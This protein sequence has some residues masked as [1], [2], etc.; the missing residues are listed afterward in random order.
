MKARIK[1]GNDNRQPQNSGAKTRWSDILNIEEGT[2]VDVISQ[3]EHTNMSVIQ[4][5]N[6][7]SSVGGKRMVPSRALEK[8][9]FDA[10]AEGF[11]PWGSKGHEQTYWA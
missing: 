2:T 1:A 5:P 7:K 4:T 10:L 11:A 6:S 9:D 3:C 8:V